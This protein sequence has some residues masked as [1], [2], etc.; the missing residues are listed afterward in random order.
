MEKEKG[1]AATDRLWTVEE[2]SYYLGV[3]ANT[4]YLWRS[5]GR[6]PASRRVGRH[7]RYRS[8]DVKAWVEKL[9]GWAIP[10]VA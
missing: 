10:G 6:G 3:P 1:T 4:L 5:E 7:L 2:V 8:E 9:D